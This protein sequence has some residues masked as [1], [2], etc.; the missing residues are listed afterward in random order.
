MGIDKLD[1]GRT[2]QRTSEI[3]TRKKKTTLSYSETDTKSNQH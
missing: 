3:V 2:A 1:N